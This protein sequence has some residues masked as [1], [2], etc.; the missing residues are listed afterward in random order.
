MLQ[1]LHRVLKGFK[2][3]GRG[4]VRAFNSQHTTTTTTTTATTTTTNTT[5]TTTA[6]STL[7]PETSRRRPKLERAWTSANSFQQDPKVNMPK[8]ST[9]FGDLG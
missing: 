4:A 5:I 8:S 6:I 1:G 7:K 3:S 9:G 2:I